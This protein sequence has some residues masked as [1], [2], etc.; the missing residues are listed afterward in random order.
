[1]MK[2][3]IE[4]LNIRLIIPFFIIIFGIISERV[5]CQQISYNISKINQDSIKVELINDNTDAYVFSSYFS[6]NIEHNKWLLEYDKHTQTV[7]INLT[8][9]IPYLGIALSDVRYLN[10]GNIIR[11][12]QNL[13]L[14]EPIKHNYTIVIN[15][16]RLKKNTDFVKPAKRD[17]SQFDNIKFHNTRAKKI[18]HYV[19]K[20]AIYDS[21]DWCTDSLFHTNPWQFYQNAKNYSQIII[22]LN[23]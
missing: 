22:N 4:Q 21:T 1:M 13:Y 19:L 10:I 11:K 2:L 16:S 5:Y 12:H 8:P 23:L 9:I 20:I 7:T 18:K 6:K 3:I 14:F 17:K 15:A